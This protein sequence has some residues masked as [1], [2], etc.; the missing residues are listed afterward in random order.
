MLNN[1]QQ[2]QDLKAKDYGISMV[3]QIEAYAIENNIPIIQQDGIEYLE[4]IIT[5]NN[6]NQILEIGTAIGYS[7]IKMALINDS[8]HVT[9]IE[10]DEERYNEAI[11][12]INNC[13][14]NNR[15]NAIFKDAL[16]DIPFDN[17]FD[18]I[19]IDAAKSKSIEFFTKYEKY[20]NDNGIIITDNINFHGLVENI[21]NI[22]NRR[23][24]ALMKKIIKYVDFLKNNELYNTEFINIGDGISISRKK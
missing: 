20:L 16:D 7:A 2:L 14:L 8:I 24:K 23:T 10:R 19:F 5:E 13:N 18:L 6:V 9:T 17:K 1:Q 22:K 11:E 21:D 3:D 4:K 15:I 12:N